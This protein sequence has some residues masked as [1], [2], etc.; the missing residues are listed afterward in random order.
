MS[1]QPNLAVLHTLFLREHNRVARELQTA[2]SQWSDQ[3]LYEEAKRIVNAEWQ[4]IIYNEYLP[5]MLGD[6]YV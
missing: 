3:R 1:E 2:N 5:I 4:H 6:T